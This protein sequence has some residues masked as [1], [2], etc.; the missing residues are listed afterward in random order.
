MNKKKID[1][2]KV[3]NRMTTRISNNKKKNQNHRQISQIIIVMMFRIQN[4][5]LLIFRINQKNIKKA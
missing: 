3:Y 1:M 2:K 5:I 4:K